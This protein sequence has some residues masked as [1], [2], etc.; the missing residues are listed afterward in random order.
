MRIRINRKGV[1]AA[2]TVSFR[3]ETAVCDS[4]KSW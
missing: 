1:D 3:A 2:G 4:P